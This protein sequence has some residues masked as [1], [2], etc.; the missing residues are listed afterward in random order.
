MWANI[1]FFKLLKFIILKLFLGLSYANKCIG[2]LGQK[3]LCYKWKTQLLA[4]YF[5]SNKVIVNKSMRNWLKESSKK[6]KEELKNDKELMFMET[7]IS[8]EVNS[9]I[10][11]IKNVYKIII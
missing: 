1:F 3:G 10:I 4:S 11:L 2:I 8:C 7:R 6:A 5:F 9:L